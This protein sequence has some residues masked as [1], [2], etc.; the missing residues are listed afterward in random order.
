MASAARSA[1]RSAGWR[2][3]QTPSSG[4]LDQYAGLTNSCQ[5]LRTADS[6]GAASPR[7]SAASWRT[8][9]SSSPTRTLTLRTS[10]ACVIAA[11]AGV[12]AAAWAVACSRS[13]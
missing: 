5:P 10:A 4:W 3:C 7:A 12:L 8:A 11:G 2:Q 6:R 13:A 1:W 9:A